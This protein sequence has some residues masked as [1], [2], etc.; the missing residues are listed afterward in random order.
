LQK[1][2]D[3]KWIIAGASSST[4]PGFMNKG[5][6]DYWILKLTIPA[7]VSNGVPGSCTTFPP[8][9]INSSNNNQWVPIT[10]NAGNAVAEIKANGNNLGV[11]NSSMF[12]NAGAVREDGTGRL[13]LD[14]TI[15]IKPQFA[16][17]SPVDVRLYIKGSEFLALKNAH[18]SFGQTAGIST[19]NDIGIFQVDG[20]CSP[21]VAT[22]SHLRN[23]TGEAWQHDYVLSASINYFSTFCFA[24]KIP[25]AP[26][27]ITQ[28]NA[29]PNTLWP[30]DHQ[31]VNVTVNY[32]ATG[33]CF[34]ITSQ[35]TVTSNEPVTG[36]GNGDVGPD[37]IVLDDHHLQL[38]AERSQQDTG[39][40]YTITVNAKTA[41]NTS[42]R[43]TIRVT[44]PYQL[45]SPLPKGMNDYTGTQDYLDQLLGSKI[46]PNPSNQYFELQV[47]S[48][49]AEKIEVNLLD[50][51]GKLITKLSALKNKPLRFG[52]ELKPGMYMVLVRQGQL[53]KTIKV[54]KQ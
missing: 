32:Q 51:S 42:C 19:I 6:D 37:W 36:T 14:R 44:V 21:T 22:V 52:D 45:G 12:I 54:V 2:T 29:S 24:N 39:R 15:T 8:I 5:K 34:P 43:K 3:G 7:S 35:L 11:I 40:V 41:F 49:S 46:T 16:Q 1:T 13:Y 30:A 9:T 38:R 18:N 4:T 47:T 31:M 10:D 27:V 20:N 25:C 26:P 48:A 28:L 50:M 53:Q 17:R 23:A 33:N